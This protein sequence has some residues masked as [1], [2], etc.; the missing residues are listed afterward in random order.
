MSRIRLN[1]L[2]TL[3]MQVSQSDVTT[4]RSVDL[5]PGQGELLGNPS[6]QQVSWLLRLI[7]CVLYEYV[8]LANAARQVKKR[9]YTKHSLFTLKAFLGITWSLA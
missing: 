9:H 6:D 3:Q 2:S 7:V 8:P 1:S 5:L 4:I